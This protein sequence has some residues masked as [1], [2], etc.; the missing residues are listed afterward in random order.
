MQILFG[1]MVLEKWII[2]ILALLRICI[3]A[4]LSL[5]SYQLLALT[6]LSQGVLLWQGAQSKA[7]LPRRTDTHILNNSL[8][9]MALI[10][11]VRG[12]C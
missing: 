4:L 9:V 12:L 10:Q 8:V 11:E 3:N 2:F 5:W 6:I 1:T 7:Q